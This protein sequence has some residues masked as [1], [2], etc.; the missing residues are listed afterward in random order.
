M[1][2]HMKVYSRAPLINSQSVAT[3]L[4]T[5][6]R[7]YQIRDNVMYV[8]T[9]LHHELLHH[10]MSLGK[11][12]TPSSEELHAFTRLPGGAAFQRQRE[13]CEWVG[14]LSVL[15]GLSWQWVEGWLAAT[16]RCLW[17]EYRQW[18]TCSHQASV[19]GRTT[20]SVI[21]EREETVRGW[22]LCSEHN[23]GINTMML[24]LCRNLGK[25]ISK[26]LQVV[27]QPVQVDTYV[28]TDKLKP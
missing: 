3:Q 28:L 7:L 21:W 12:E 19:R 14:R 18:G 17:C 22:I 15:G 5:H 13:G 16:C 1:H 9:H 6:G 24:A 11:Y 8:C 27:V 10:F 4:N 23:N 25:Q 20:G 2:S 26:K